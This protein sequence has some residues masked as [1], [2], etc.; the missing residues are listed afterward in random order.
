MRKEDGD[1]KYLRIEVKVLT[2]HYSMLH[3]AGTRSS[4]TPVARSVATDAR[5]PLTSRLAP[6]PAAVRSCRASNDDFIKFKKK[7]I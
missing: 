6:R 5:D 1:V 3:V 7:T 2:V 4:D